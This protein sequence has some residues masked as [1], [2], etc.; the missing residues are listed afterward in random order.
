[1]EE[2]QAVDGGGDDALAGVAKGR[3]GARHVDEVHDGAAEHEPERVRIVRQH[4]LGMSVADSDDRLGVD[5]G[6][7]CDRQGCGHPEGTA[8]ITAQPAVVLEVVADPHLELRRAE[9]AAAA[10]RGEERVFPILVEQ[11][12]PREVE[13]DR[14]P[15]QEALEPEAIRRAAVAQAEAGYGL[16]GGP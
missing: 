11:R 7:V 8:L 10:L 13:V 12:A 15:E 3:D 4:H 6:P 16:I 2:L 5:E 9:R 14:E 1:M